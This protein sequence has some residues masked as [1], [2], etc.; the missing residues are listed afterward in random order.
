MLLTKKRRKR[1]KIN[2]WH[3]EKQPAAEKR[4]ENTTTSLVKEKQRSVLLPCPI[5]VGYLSIYLSI[6]YSAIRLDR[7]G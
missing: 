3:L 6:Y 5:Q 4:T 2:K 7:G 1:K